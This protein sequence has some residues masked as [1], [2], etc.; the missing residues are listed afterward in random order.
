DTA[1]FG[2]LKQVSIGR[3]VR[4]GG[5]PD[6]EKIACDALLVSGG[7]SPTLNLFAQAGGKLKFDSAIRAF[8]PVSTYPSIEIVGAAAE[9][10]QG[11]IGERISPVGNPARQWVDLLHD[12]TVA[13]IEQ[14]VRE[15]YT[16][17]EHIKRYTTLGMSVDQGKIGQAPAAE[18][19][20][21]AQ[22]ID[23]S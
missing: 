14:A 21:K 10:P 13:D 3:L 7:W 19:I 6:T 2:A 15:N 5:V 12:V 17:V 23:L 16:S 9:T 11:E 22:D 4:T 18:V 8:R 20:A 1:G